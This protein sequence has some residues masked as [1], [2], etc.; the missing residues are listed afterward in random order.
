MIARFLIVVVLGNLVESIARLFV[1]LE[2]KLRK[3]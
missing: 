1:F 3:I 2:K